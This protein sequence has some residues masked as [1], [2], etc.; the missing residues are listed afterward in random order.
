MA[1]RGG[2]PASSKEAAPRA[3]TS[4][5]ALTNVSSLMYSLLYILY[6]NQTMARRGGNP[7]SSKEAAPRALI[8]AGALTNVSSLMY[9]L[10]YILYVN[11][12][13]ARRGGNPASH[14]G[15]TPSPH[16]SGSP[17]QYIGQKRRRRSL[18]Q[19]GNTP[20]P[21]L[22]RSPHQY[23]HPRAVTQAHQAHQAQPSTT[24][25]NHAQP[26]TTKAAGERKGGAGGEAASCTATT[27]PSSA[28]CTATTRRVIENPKCHLPVPALHRGYPIHVYTEYIPSLVGTH[29]SF[30]C[31][32]GKQIA[33]SITIR[34]LP[35]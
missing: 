15:S 17:H 22:S 32:L 9:S 27:N 14:R 24:K 4:A 20:H 11:Q 6:V 30:F 29:A 34:S 7:A 1:R 26:S 23:L 2:N 35:L 31:V 19:R 16:L 28:N 18:P 5:G 21:Q 33:T 8:S 25:H 10:L 12:T 3:L 13:S